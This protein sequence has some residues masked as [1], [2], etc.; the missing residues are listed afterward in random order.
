MGI[1]ALFY[2]IA[3]VFPS[4]QF[5]FK[6]I[7]RIIATSICVL[8]CAVGSIFVTIKDNNTAKI[9]VRGGESLCFTIVDTPGED[10]LILSD[11]S[12][13]FSDYSLTSIR[14]RYVVEEIDTVI[15]LQG[16]DLFFV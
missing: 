5:N 13:S 14:Q 8:V 9:Y 6:K 2:Y 15:I 16:F 10:T 1:F 7:T 3:L 4:E 11:V 12:T